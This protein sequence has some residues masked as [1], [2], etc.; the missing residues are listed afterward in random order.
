MELSHK[1]K[2]VTH[3]I[4]LKDNDTVIVTLPDGTKVD[5]STNGIY[6]MKIDAK[7]D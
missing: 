4:T 1:L 7:Q 5:I 6:I 2:K 3:R